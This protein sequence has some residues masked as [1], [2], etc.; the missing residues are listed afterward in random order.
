MR[1]LL[2]VGMLSCGLAGFAHAEDEI[3]PRWRT[4]FDKAKSEAK[5]LSRPMFLVFR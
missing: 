5:R 4:D 2:A 3:D 1:T